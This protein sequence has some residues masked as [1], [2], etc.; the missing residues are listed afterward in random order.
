MVLDLIMA[1]AEASDGISVE[2]AKNIE[3]IKSELLI[4]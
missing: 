2:E 4:N 1:M 3:E